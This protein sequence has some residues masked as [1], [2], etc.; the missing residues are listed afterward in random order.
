M[1]DNVV[2]MPKKEVYIWR[3]PCGCT[4][5][6][7]NDTGVIECASCDKDVD[8]PEYN[9]WRAKRPEVPFNAPDITGED[10]KVTTMATTEQ[11]LRRVVSELIAEIEINDM[12][13][14]HAIVRI[15][16]NGKVSAWGPVSE[17]R[18]RKS[19]L[20]RRMKEAQDILL[21]FGVK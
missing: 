7:L 5:F 6:V 21:G 12:K 14:L 13:Q 11:S 9:G 17:G 19:W 15:Y 1:S 16:N 2:P 3:C 20:R 8:V 4:S 10:T 18:K